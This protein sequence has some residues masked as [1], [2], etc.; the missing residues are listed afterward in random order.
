MKPPWTQSLELRLKMGS[1]EGTIVMWNGSARTFLAALHSYQAKFS[2]AKWYGSLLDSCANK[3]LAWNREA[4]KSYK[5]ISQAPFHTCKGLFQVLGPWHVGVQQCYGT[6]TLCCRQN[7]DIEEHVLFI[8]PRRYVVLLFYR[9]RTIPWMWY[10]LKW[11]FEVAS[12][13]SARE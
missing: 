7:P 2:G 9:W 3:H 6:W 12:H 8:Q 13:I 1:D 5:F 4:Y 10:F 11:H